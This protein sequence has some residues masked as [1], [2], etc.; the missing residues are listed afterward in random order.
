M[1]MLNNQR[2]TDIFATIHRLFTKIFAMNLPWFFFR[3]SSPLTAQ[4]L[5][6]TSQLAKVIGSGED[7][8]TLQGVN[9]G[10]RCFFSDINVVHVWFMC[11]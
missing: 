3:P 11:C 9:S 8:G 7:Q 2:V 10:K 4:A 6:G 5:H 1:A